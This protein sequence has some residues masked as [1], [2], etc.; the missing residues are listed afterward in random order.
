M[1]LFKCLHLDT[2]SSRVISSDSEPAFMM[3][4]F[5]GKHKS[6]FLLP[7]TYGRDVEPM[8]HFKL[9]WILLSFNSQMYFESSMLFSLISFL[10]DAVR[11]L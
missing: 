2:G 1:T 10:K 4:N 9:C 3:V 6:H 7:H 8:H 11:F 5:S